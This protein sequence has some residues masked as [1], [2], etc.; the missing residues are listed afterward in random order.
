MY[1]N[2]VANEL[3]SKSV[4]DSHSQSNLRLKMAKPVVNSR[5]YSQGNSRRNSW[6][7][8]L[9]SNHVRNGICLNGRKKRGKKFLPNSEKRSHKVKTIVRNYSA[10]RLVPEQSSHFHWSEPK[11]SSIHLD[12]KP[13]LHFFDKLPKKRE[14]CEDF[15]FSLSDPDLC[16]S[17]LPV[18]SNSAKYSKG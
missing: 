11:M 13:R 12:H 17:N 15:G 16:F 7:K 9:F 5:T 18:H 8:K 10:S 14:N 3:L 2:Y 6:P 4:F 1:F